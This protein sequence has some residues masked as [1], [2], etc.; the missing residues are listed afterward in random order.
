MSRYVEEDFEKQEESHAKHM[1]KKQYIFRKMISPGRF[2][3]QRV[4]MTQIIPIF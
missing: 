4:R 2:E 3:G 1:E